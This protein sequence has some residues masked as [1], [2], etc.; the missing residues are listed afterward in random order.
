[1]EK[2]CEREHEGGRRRIDNHAYKKKAPFNV[3][4]DR[5]KITISPKGA[6]ISTIFSLE[7]IKR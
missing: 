4:T 1:M 5:K 7:T 2:E 6:P 3:R